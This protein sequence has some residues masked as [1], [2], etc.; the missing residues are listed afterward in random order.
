MAET[1]VRLIWATL[2]DLGDRFG[3]LLEILADDERERA[4][5]FRVES[6]RRRFVLARVL[7]RGELS[8]RVG[9]ASNALEFGVR[10]HGKPHL[11]KPALDSPPCFNLSHSGDLVVVAI[12]EVELGADVE[13]L[14]PVVNAEKL[15]RRFFGSAERRAI[16]ELDGPARDRAFLRI[17]TQKEAY[18]KATGL[19]VGMRLREVETEPDP[20]APPRIHTIGG[21]AEEAARWQLHEVEIPGAVCTVAVLGEVSGVEVV[22]RTPADF[23]RT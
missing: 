12:A 17:W 2:A 3:G 18:L 14:R 7:L 21:D 1:T 15:A 19:G 16:T 8:E 23:D 20:A 11:V 22:R 10:P 13:C 4:G 6:A 5:R 9:Q